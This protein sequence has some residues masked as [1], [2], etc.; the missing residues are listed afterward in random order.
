MKDSTNDRTTLAS[1][2]ERSDDMPE[3]HAQEEEER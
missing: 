3:E 1:G 2:E